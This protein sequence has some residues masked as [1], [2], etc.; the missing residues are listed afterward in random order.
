MCAGRDEERGRTGGRDSAT[1]TTVGA[2]A[3]GVVVMCTPVVDVFSLGAL[4]LS[5]SPDSLRSRLGMGDTLTVTCP[6]ARFS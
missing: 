4:S 6:E 3:I 1:W 2:S 5:E